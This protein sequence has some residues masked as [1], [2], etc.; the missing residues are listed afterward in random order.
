MAGCRDFHREAGL[1]VAATQSACAERMWR[2][3][4]ERSEESVA[5][6]GS[7]YDL[8]ADAPPVESS[9]APLY[10]AKPGYGTYV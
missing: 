1:E 10:I 6:T 9:I 8:S 2:R 4:A 3:E 7:R 5:P